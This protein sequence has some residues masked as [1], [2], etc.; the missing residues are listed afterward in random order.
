MV[1]HPLKK[2]ET[3]K[4]YDPECPFSVPKT[5]TQVKKTIRTSLG[6]KVQIHIIWKDT[7]F[8]LR[9]LGMRES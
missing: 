7:G 5:R 4:Y 2:R 1:Y 9:T 8:L 6:Q 3:V